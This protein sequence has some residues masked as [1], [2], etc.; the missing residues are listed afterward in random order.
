MIALL[1][2]CSRVSVPG[3]PS[4]LPSPVAQLEGHGTG[5][6]VIRADF[7]TLLARDGSWKD[8]GAKWLRIMCR[9]FCGPKGLKYVQF[10]R[11]KRPSRQS[12]SSLVP[13]LSCLAWLA[14]WSRWSHRPRRSGRSW[15]VLKQQNLNYVQFLLQKRPSPSKSGHLQ[16]IFFILAHCSAVAYKRHFSKGFDTFTR[17][18]GAATEDFFLFATL[19]RP[20]A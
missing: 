17:S 13:R 11:Q 12:C 7:R 20:V 3:R 4:V 5:R 14:T 15:S 1:G 9:F 16:V 8:C 10:L 18:E 19:C 2:K 6:S